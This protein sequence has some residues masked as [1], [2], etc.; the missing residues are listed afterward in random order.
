MYSN[1]LRRHSRPKPSDRVKPR[2][3]V[4]D[5]RRQLAWAVLASGLMTTIVLLATMAW[6]TN[7][8]GQEAAPTSEVQTVIQRQLDAFQ[9]DDAGAAF[10]I[11]A[12][13][14]QQKFGTPARFL[15][16]VKR[17]YAPVYRPQ[18]VR[19]LG[20][21]PRGPDWEQRV[22]VSG[23]DGALV[24]AVYTLRNIEGQWR[25]TSCVLERPAAAT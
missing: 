13:V 21:K 14:I 24:T 22:L 6:T 4:I 19:F 23:P 8:V 20:L 2:A 7:A 15:E 5:R 18:S 17:Y 1:E 16:L 25:I 11:A 12:P 10:A 3:A 9:R